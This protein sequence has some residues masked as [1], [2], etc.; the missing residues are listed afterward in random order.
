MALPITT[1]SSL[2]TLQDDED[3]KPRVSCISSPPTTPLSPPTS[4]RPLTCLCRG[5]GPPYPFKMLRPGTHLTSTLLA[6]QDFVAPRHPRVPL[7]HHPDRARAGAVGFALRSQRGRR[8]S[9]VGQGSGSD[10]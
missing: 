6:L 10:E 3:H 2:L 7:L 1:L 4:S 9:H 8:G 5:G